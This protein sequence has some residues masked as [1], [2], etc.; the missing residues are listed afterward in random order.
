M[1]FTIND[2]S[3]F[4]QTRPSNRK[5]LVIEG[6]RNTEATQKTSKHT[7]NAIH[8]TPESFARVVEANP[9]KDDS[10]FL[11]S[12]LLYKPRTPLSAFASISRDNNAAIHTLGSTIDTF[13]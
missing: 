8:Q 7:A 3:Y 1:S 9:V 12:D 2:N 4:G 6:E 5:P 11:S 10:A 13:V